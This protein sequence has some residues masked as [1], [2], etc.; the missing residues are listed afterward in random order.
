M[1]MPKI[2]S[3][4][5]STLAWYSLLHQFFSGFDAMQNATSDG[6]VPYTSGCTWAM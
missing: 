2:Q 4:D 6:S 1:S 3:N 5:S